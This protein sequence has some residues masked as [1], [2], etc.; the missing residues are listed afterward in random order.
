MGFQQITHKLYTMKRRTFTKNL[1]LG[2][3]AVSTGMIQ[4]EPVTHILTLSFDDG[5]RKSFHQIGEIF[6]DNGMSACLNVIAAGHLPEFE[7]VDKWI[8]PKLMGDFEDWNTLKSKGHEVNLHSW[9]HLKLPDQPFAYAQELI[10]KCVEYFKKNLDGYAYEESVFNFPFNASN[11]QLEDFVLT[12][13]KALRTQG[14]TPYQA[15]P[16]PSKDMSMKLG[17]WSHGPKNADEFVETRIREFLKTDGGWLILNLHGL[18]K[19][20]WGPIS[21]KYLATLLPRLRLIKQLE[22]LPT[23]MVIEKYT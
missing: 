21:K 15:N 1:A 19:E 6:A 16:F 2:S 5:F 11:P 14:H 4:T 8:K 9:K 22:V 10:E 20:G 18:N 7:R 3:L 17:C 23:G 12:K 13:V